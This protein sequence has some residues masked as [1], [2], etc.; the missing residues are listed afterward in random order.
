MST[1]LREELDALARTQ[2]FSPDPATWDRGR[3][4]RRRT[5]VGAVVAA[6]VVVA[7]LGGGVA[8]WRTVDREA[9]TAS[10]EV[11][12]GGAI[13]SSIVDPGELDLELDLAV[14][15]ASTAFV[16][17][18]KDLVVVTATDGVPHS[19]GVPGWEPTGPA[20]AL[21][22]DGRFLAYQQAADEGAEIGVL[23]LVSGQRSAI[24]AQPGDRLTINTISWSPDG[25]WLGWAA[26]RI[27]TTP[28]FAGR[29]RRTGAQS[30]RVEPELN[31]VSAAVADDG[32]LA[33]GSVSGA[34]F[35]R[36]GTG[37]LERVRAG[38]RGAPAS[39]SPDSTRLALATS[40]GTASYTLDVAAGKVLSH[41]FP[42]DTIGTAVVRPLG[43][44]D[45]R[46]QLLLVQEMSGNGDGE[47][48]LTTPEVSGTSTWRRSVGRVDGTVASSVS[49]AVDLVP[50][51][52]GTSP[53]QLTH[54][55]PQP[56]ERDISWIIGLG[57][58]AAIAVLMGLRWLWR[59]LLS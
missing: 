29:V 43:W 24:L 45:D 36:S 1:D 51:L 11:V 12:E 16:S 6:L 27:A 39:F 44:T 33:L 5:R 53:Q 13:P 32:T 46:H 58:A 23:D 57:V 26:S 50:D 20:P 17:T 31:A 30:W 22:T 14:G 54:E 9:R 48:V 59:R 37:G 8:L 35:I 25:E 41:P 2:T 19:L 38:I 18:A 56:P 49:V 3:R 34:V 42:D 4:A 21:S 47:L 55:F 15:R 28:S 52:D 40:P 10:G 7:G